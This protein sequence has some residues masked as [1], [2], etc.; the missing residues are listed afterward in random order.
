MS[1]ARPPRLPWFRY[2]GPW[3]IRPLGVTI[4]LAIFYLGVSSGITF[5]SQR[6][7]VQAL[8]R[9][10]MGTLAT[11]ALGGG[12]LWLWRRLA[13]RFV[14]SPLGYAVTIVSA[15]TVAV[16]FRFVSGLTPDI[17][18]DQPPFVIV[19]AFIRAWLL[20]LLTLAFLGIGERRLL[21]Q[22]DRAETALRIAR[23]QQIQ[24]LTADEGVREQ[25]SRFLHD[26]VQAR[27]I[28]AC[29]ELQSIAASSTHDSDRLRG[30]VDRLEQLR[31]SD[32]RRAAR[33]LSPNL[34]EIDLL[35]ALEA[36]GAQYRP[37]MITQVDV[38]EVI[39]Q[40]RQSIDPR[41]LDRKSVV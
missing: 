29:L 23:E 18:F 26:R 38:D 25:T 2:V 35:S 31:T 13:P 33:N 39:D 10:T 24:I 22:A 9:Y 15:G 11:A 19:F 8:P 4:S 1:Q 7:D 36:L 17:A 5:L 34:E 3:P 14:L 6:A 41:S 32:V 20:I 37:S 40:D 30:V 21:F 12:V 28:A 27:L 16:L